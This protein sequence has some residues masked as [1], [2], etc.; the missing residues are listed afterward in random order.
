MWKCKNVVFKADT[1]HVS[2]GGHCTEIQ[3]IVL[4]YPI[5]NEL[6]TNRTQKGHQNE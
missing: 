4:I 2:D 3:L 1:T 5:L 6:P